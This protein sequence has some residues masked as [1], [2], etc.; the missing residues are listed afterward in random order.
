[1]ADVAAAASAGKA[2]WLDSSKVSFAIFNAAK[3]AYAAQGE[4]AARFDVVVWGRGEMVMWNMPSST[5]QS[6]LLLPRVRKLR[7][8]TQ[9]LGGREWSVFK[10]CHLQHRQQASAPPTGLCL[11]EVR[12]LQIP[13]VKSRLPCRQLSLRGVTSD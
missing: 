11:P 7:A 2:V 12:K 3:Q 4:E 13:G 10:V 5:P 8:L 9:L 6:R 1:M